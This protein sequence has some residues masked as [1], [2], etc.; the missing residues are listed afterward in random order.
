MMTVVTIVAVVSAVVSI[1]VGCLGNFAQNTGQYQDG[2]GQTDRL[3]EVH[4]DI[5]PCMLLRE[6]VLALSPTRKKVGYI[7]DCWSA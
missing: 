2:D 7:L 3:Q 5:S 4:S 1:G 6:P